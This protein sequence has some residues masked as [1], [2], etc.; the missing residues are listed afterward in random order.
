L[1]LPLRLRLLAEHRAKDGASVIR[2]P[3]LNGWRLDHDAATAA[4]LA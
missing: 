2:S 3:A 4:F 1:E